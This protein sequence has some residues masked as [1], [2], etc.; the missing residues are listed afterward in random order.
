[1]NDFR[2]QFSPKELGER[3]SGWIKQYAERKAGAQSLVIGISGGIDSALVSTLCAM[4][5]MPTYVV[6]LPIHSFVGHGS[7]SRLHAASLK[8]RFKNVKIL[9]IDLTETFDLFEKTMNNSKQESE[10]GFANSRSRLRMM[11]LYQVATTHSGIVVGTG[12]K[13]ED[14]GVGFF[15]KYGDGGV[16]I[17]PIAD[18]TKTEVREI[19]RELGVIPEILFVS[20]T[21]GLWE[22][23][24]TDEDQ[25]G[26]TYPELEKAMEFAEENPFFSLEDLE[27]LSP[28]EQEVL[29]I[30]LDRHR[31]NLHKMN[32][33][34]VFKI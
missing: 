11:S 33:I 4:T 18:F 21:D 27:K 28:R 12:N 16:D 31:K 34:P 10:L 17:S 19:A 14:F 6:M 15:T 32:P 23:G 29:H 24:R 22:D 13:I 2:K 30:Y 26:A 1:M 25:I 20:P 7:L 3:A 8:K 9:E 5:G